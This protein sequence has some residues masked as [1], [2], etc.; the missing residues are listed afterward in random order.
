ME[1]FSFLSC[2]HIQII[3]EFIEQRLK[4]GLKL[5]NARQVMHLLS[6]ADDAIFFCVQLV[7]LI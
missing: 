5:C 6:L 7:L 1:R 2:L 3:I 4:N